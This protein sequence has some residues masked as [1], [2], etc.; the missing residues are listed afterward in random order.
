[1]PKHGNLKYEHE[2]FYRLFPIPGT[3]F[4]SEVLDALA[5]REYEQEDSESE[6]P[7]G[8][9]Y[10]GQFLIHEISRLLRGDSIP[11]RGP[12]SESDLQQLRNPS[13]DLDS[14]Y[15][16]NTGFAP[17]VQNSN[18]KFTSNSTHVH[19]G[20]EIIYDLPRH[21]NGKALIGDSRN[22][23]NFI[24]AQLHVLFMNAHNK[25]HDLH[26]TE[27]PGSSVDTTRSELSLLFQKIIVNDF[28][29]SVMDPLVYHNLFVNPLDEFLIDVIPGEAARIPVEFAGAAFRF[30]HSL[31]R[32]FYDTGSPKQ[33]SLAEL[34]DL[35]GNGGHWQKIG[36]ENLMDWRLQFDLS[37]Y[38]STADHQRAKSINTSLAVRLHELH[39]EE[40]GNQ[41]LSKR[42]LRRSREIDLPCGQ[43]IVNYLTETHCSYSVKMDLSLVDLLKLP[44][45]NPNLWLLIRK[46]GLSKKI[47]LWSYI[48]LEPAFHTGNVRPGC[49]LGT[50]GSIIIGEVLRSLIVTSR[51]SIFSG[52]LSETKSQFM[53]YMNQQ[54]PNRNINWTNV[55]M[56]DLIE[57]VHNY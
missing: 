26:L 50:L 30:G 57:F 51:N 41:D 21:R 33:K 31:I 29:E 38:G 49:R 54:H 10:V 16:T 42:N 25:L 45:A 39:L 27:D 34:F 40:I 8:N 14:L 44:D 53:L 4:K 55:R 56:S 47:P 6:I 15:G 11:T 1:M 22:D 35:T 2:P 19:N 32:D 48:L 17:F 46:Y 37:D 52:N 24:I 7:A 36:K 23:E 5:N 12:I 18:G 20:E 13:L 43:D 28:L 3:R 9:T